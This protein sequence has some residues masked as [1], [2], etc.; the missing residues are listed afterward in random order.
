MRAPLST[1]SLVAS[2]APVGLN[3]TLNN[4]QLGDRAH[5]GLFSNIDEYPYSRNFSLQSWE[6][7]ELASDAILSARV[8]GVLQT[9]HEDGW[10]TSRGYSA[11]DG[12]WILV[13]EASDGYWGL[14]VAATSPELLDRI[15]EMITI[16]AGESN[17]MEANEI[18]MAIWSEHPMGGGSRRWG[19]M[20]VGVWDEVMG[21]Y[22]EKTRSSLEALAANLPDRSQGG[23]IVF[24]GPAGTGKTRAI[25][26]LCHAWAPHASLGVVVDSD[27]MLCS[28]SYLADVMT[29]AGVDQRQV[30]IAEDVDEM[31]A[32][33]PKSH[34]TA[35]LLNIA[36]G[37]VGR[38]CGAGTLIV[39]TANLALEEIAPYVTRPGRA[40]SVIEFEAFSPE[41]A[42]GWFGSRG[43]T[44]EVTGP[45]SLA[46]M[47]AVVNN[48]PSED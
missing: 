3:V 22:T 15:T 45:M 11:Q 36:D 32:V 46:E 26:A 31:V 35:K 38:L 10:R 29:A 13:S 43:V 41:E 16:L 30:I 44:H 12:S 20:K 40:A 34:E 9:S 28:A 8:G 5:Y 27:R 17:N 6:S 21:N 39:L 7:W 24:G 14:S 42:A 23:L 37:L 19:A 48:V 2:G 4:A 25:E 1:S 33:G 18:S 47:F